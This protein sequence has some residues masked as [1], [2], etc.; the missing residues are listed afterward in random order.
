MKKTIRKYIPIVTGVMALGALL[1][2]PLSANAQNGSNGGD[3]ANPDP[4]KSDVVQ[5]KLKDRS[6]ERCQNRE[7]VISNVMT[8]V[9]DRGEKQISV[10][11]SIQQKVQNFYVEKDISTDGY[12]TL[13]ANVEAKKQ[14]AT[15]EVNRVRT[16][17][18]SFSCGSDDPKGTATQFK[19][20]ATAQSSSVGEYKNAV[21]DLIVEIKTSIGADSS[22]EEV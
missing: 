2:V 5:K 6:L 8:R 16:L 11:Q 15:N 1:L 14:A 10:I 17:T 18:R 21:H 12:D 22:T 13:V 19:T 3:G 9:G 20:Q 4:V 7:R